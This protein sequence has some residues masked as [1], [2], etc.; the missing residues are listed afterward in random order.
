MVR[1]YNPKLVSYIYAGSIIAG[2]ADG[3]FI[4]V[5]RNEDSATYSRG[6]QGSGTRVLVSD[7]SGRITCTLQQTS[8]SNAIFAAQLAAMELQ[9]TGVSSALVKDGSGLDLHEA[10]TAWVVKPADAGYANELENREW[11]VETDELLMNVL[12][13]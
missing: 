6:A 13:Q 12:G 11:I 8:P 7:K 9:G 10:A 5:A 2:F 4:N 1:T 3:T